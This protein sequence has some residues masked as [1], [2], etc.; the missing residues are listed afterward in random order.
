[1]HKNRNQFKISSENMW[2][3]IKDQF[4]EGGGVYILKCYK[5]PDNPIP[6]SVNRLLSNDEEGVLYIGMETNFLSRVPDLKKSISQQYKSN[7]HECGTRYK[8]NPA[9]LKMFPFEN[10]YLELLDSENPGDTESKLLQKYEE[11]FGEL[12][13]FNR[14]S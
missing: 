7:T 12:P 1:M 14:S 5:S 9:I 13:P 8:S 11:E 3:E 4:G 6:I 10:L 2:Y